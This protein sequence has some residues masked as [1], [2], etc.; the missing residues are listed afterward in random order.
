MNARKAELA[1]ER[2][3][4][5]SAT[6]EPGKK[7]ARS[8]LS[9]PEMYGFSDPLVR[10]LLEELPGVDN[11]SKYVRMNAPPASPASKKASSKHAADDAMVMRHDTDPMSA[12]FAAVQQDASADRKEAENK[13]VPRKAP[14]AQ[15]VA[16]K[17]QSKP[18]PEQKAA[19]KVVSA[20]AP[21]V[22][23]VPVAAAAAAASADGAVSTVASGPAP[24]QHK[25]STALQNLRVEDVMSVLTK[26]GLFLRD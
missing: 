4:A 22:A 5:P 23:K 8:T 3:E 14:A 2:G 18:K 11:L 13:A 24:T 17:P 15:K 16:A 21:V 26:S 10:A 20:K 7:K 25:I 12:L 6:E 9:G 1:L 19:P